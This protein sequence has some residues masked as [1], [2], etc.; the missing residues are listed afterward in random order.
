M[1]LLDPLLPT[2]W[3]TAVFWFGRRLATSV[4]MGAASVTVSTFWRW[5]LVMTII[6]VVPITSIVKRATVVWSV[7]K[8]GVTPWASVPQI[9]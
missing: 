6:T 3:R 8:T 5:G 7:S 9:I 1:E 4:M 2:F